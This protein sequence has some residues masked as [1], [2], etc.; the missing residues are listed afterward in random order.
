MMNVLVHDYYTVSMEMVW[1]ILQKD[2]PELKQYLSN[3][4]TNTESARSV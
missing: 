1:A 3:Y 4:I 2:L